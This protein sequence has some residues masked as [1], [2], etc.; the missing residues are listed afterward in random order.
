[1]AVAHGAVAEYAL[2]DALTVVAVLAAEVVRVAVLAVVL[3][4]VL[5]LVAVGA[6]K[7]YVSSAYFLIR[8]T[9]LS[10]LFFI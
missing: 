5:T 4:L 7:L 10:L 3:V 1:M 2:L 9:M 8:K 6:G